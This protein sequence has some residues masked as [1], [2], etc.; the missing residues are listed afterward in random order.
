MN[1]KIAIITDLHWG[2]RNNSQY[3]LDRMEEFYYGFFIPYCLERN[4]K[5]IWILGDVFEN[6]KQVNVNIINKFY[7]FL[8][9][10]RNESFTVYCIA[11]NHDYYYKNTDLVCSLKPI[12]A[13]FPNAY[14]F[15]K[16]EIMEF[17]GMKTGFMNWIFPD[18]M[19]E[20]IRWIEESNADYLCGHFEIENFEIVRGLSCQEGLSMKIFNHFKRV[21]S[22]HFHIRAQRGNINYLGN[23]YQTNWGEAGYQKGFHVF[24][25]KTNELEFVANPI[26]IYSIIEYNENLKIKDF[27]FEE[28]QNKIVRINIPSGQGKNKNKVELFIEKMIDVAF[29]VE[30][31]DNIDILITENKNM[32]SNPLEIIQLFLE[33]S[34][35]DDVADKT[36]VQKLLLDIFQEAN[37]KDTIC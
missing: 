22:G 32:I 27:P 29:N 21:F 9:T 4:I 13:A 36:M 12:F 23:P 14:L 35:I 10:L 2:V 19:Q 5:T 7:N 17:D 31:V 1:K 20:A 30:V 28:Y 15:D 24:I 3:F 6:R 37:E 34:N 8:H 16:K 25:P 11:G 18:D 26:Q 33:N